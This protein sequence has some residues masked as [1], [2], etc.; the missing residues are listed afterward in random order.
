MTQTMNREIKSYRVSYYG[1]GKKVTRP[2]SYRAIVSLFDD[3]G[4]IAALYFHNDSDTM[5][6]ADHLPD[7]GQPMSHYPIEDFPR[8]LDML[9]N[10][11]PIYYHQ[12]STWPTMAGIRTTLEPVAEGEPA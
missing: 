12:W 8:I 5:P 10:E 6:D 3:A 11:G 9:R 4:H 7:S 1:G 2:Y